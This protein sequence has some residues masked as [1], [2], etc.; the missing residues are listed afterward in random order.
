MWRV[1][2]LARVRE[3]PLATEV[4]RGRIA[5]TWLTDKRTTRRAVAEK[6]AI[7]LRVDDGNA[8]VRVRR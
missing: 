5:R 3:Q 7:G 6:V 1:Q 4:R 8:V 2:T